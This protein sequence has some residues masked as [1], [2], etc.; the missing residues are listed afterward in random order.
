MRNRGA[1][2]LARSRLCSVIRHSMRAMR[3]KVA[4]F[5]WLHLLAV[6][7]LLSLSCT[8]ADAAEKRTGDPSITVEVASPTT[9]RPPPAEIPLEEVSTQ[10]MHVDTLIRGF[11]AN[12]ADN[13]EVETIAKFLPPLQANLNLDLKSTAAILKE[14]PGPETLQSQ[15]EIWYQRHLQ[16]TEWLKLL[17]DRTAKLQVAMAQLKKLQELWSKTREAEEAINAPEPIVQQIDRTLAAIQAAQEP[18]RTQRDELLRLQSDVAEALATCNSSLAQIAALQQ[19]AVGGLLTPQSPPIWDLDLEGRANLILSD[20]LPQVAA[21]YRA[22]VLQYIRDPSRHM[23]RHLVIFIL[24][25]LIL[26]G[27]RRRL[28]KAEA[29]ASR[30][31]HGSVVFDHVFAAALLLTLM[32]VTE[33]NSPAPVS[34]KRL[35]QIAALAPIIILTRRVVLPSFIPAI[36]ALAILLVIDTVRGAVA[37]D[38]AMGQVIFVLEAV[39]GIIVLSWVLISEGRKPAP[40]L[41]RTIMRRQILDIFMIVLLAI[42]L[43]AAVFGYMRLARL[44]IPGVLAGGALALEL[45][46]SVQ[47]AIA[48]LAYVF[49]VPPLGS[50]KLIQHHRDLLL[51]R[52]YRISLWLIAAAW[53]GRCLDYL[54]LLQPAESLATAFF[55]TRMERGSISTSV[56]DIAAFLLTVVSAYLL[57]RFIRFVLEEDV[58]PRTAIPTGRS[59][60]VSSLLNYT[61]IA[62]GFVLATAFLGVDMT[63]MTVLAGAFGVG[64]GFG[65]QSIVNNFVSGLILLFE[66]PIEL[67]DSVQIGDLQGVVRQIGIRASIMRTA[68]GAERIVPNANLIT[69]EV[70][71]WTLTD[72]LRRL[73]LPVRVNYGCEPRKVMEVL[74]G[75]ARAHPKVLKEPAPDCLFMS[76][77]DTSINFELCVWTDYSNSQQVHSDLNVAI[78]DAIYAAG[79]SFPSP[80]SDIPV[81]SDGNQSA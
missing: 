21:S 62:A 66:R 74:E 73:E 42:G 6:V 61:I 24:L 64:I 17:T 60:A 51:R 34:V 77:A 33:P 25:S 47:V 2:V 5:V 36:Y 49:R 9:A 50:L 15:E 69:Q 14:Q 70:T 28:A 30:P 57:S 68:Q 35:F 44:A 76:Y 22:D 32:I 18:Y 7:L 55:N 78:Y 16:L 80:R 45:Y 56:G 81:V 12:L 37:S 67:G 19:T 1:L 59:Y 71:N 8:C 46:A 13:T 11:A 26:F 31:E 72:R 48:L 27:A 65:L 10:A 79:M 3:L 29:A 41:D 52:I 54:G 53:L 38:P 23:P 40:F 63:K 20:R 4:G 43:A 75:V 58:Y 39:I